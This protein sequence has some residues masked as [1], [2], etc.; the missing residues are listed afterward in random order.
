MA[1]MSEIQAHLAMFTRYANDHMDVLPDEVD[2]GHVGSSGRVLEL[3]EQ[4]NSF[5]NLK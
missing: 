5:L 3:L 4:I 1:N 2:W